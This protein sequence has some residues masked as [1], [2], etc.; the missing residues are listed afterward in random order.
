MTLSPV[1]LV[2]TYFLFY[3]NFP[4]EGVAKY[5]VETLDIQ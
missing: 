3:P 1:S 5:L 2:S 4:D